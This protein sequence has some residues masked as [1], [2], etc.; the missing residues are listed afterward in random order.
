MFTNMV[1]YGQ[2]IELEQKRALKVALKKARAMESSVYQKFPY[3]NA[4]EKS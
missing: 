1:V 2:T 4:F 3:K